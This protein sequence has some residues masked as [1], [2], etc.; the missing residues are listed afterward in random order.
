MNYPS[1]SEQKHRVFI[2]YSAYLRVQFRESARLAVSVRN[3]NYNLV[4]ADL[5]NILPQKNT[6]VFKDGTLAPLLIRLAWHSC[7]TYDKYTRT[8]GSN[9][10][11]MRYHLEASDEGNVGLEVARLSLEPI[12]R[13]HPWITYA[14]LWI[15]AGVVSIEACKGPSIKWRDGRVDY[16]D[17]LLVPPNGRLPLGGGDASHVRTIFSRMGFNDQETVALIGAHS[18]G[19]LH[20]HRSGFDGPWTSNPAKCD[21]EFYKLLLGNVWTLVDSPTGRKQYVNSTG[22]VMMPSDMSLIEDANFRF[23]V[24]QYAVSEELWRDHF[25]LAFEKLTELGR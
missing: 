23:W 25:A 17:D 16:E 18:L 6:T 8:G 10:A 12:K 1:V 4:R 3:K 21:N 14:D 5:H 13:K 11:T 19:R 9:G 22:Q 2:I 15:L 7:A 20:P 24:D